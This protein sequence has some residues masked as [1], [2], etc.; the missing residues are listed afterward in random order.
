MMMPRGKWW[1]S[2]V[3]WR[4]ERFWEGLRWA[5]GK[6]TIHAEVECPYCNSSHEAEI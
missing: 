5:V 3:R 1:Q 6:G 2:R 4:I